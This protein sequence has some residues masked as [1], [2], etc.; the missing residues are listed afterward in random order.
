MANDG[1]SRWTGDISGSVLDLIGRTPLVE[2]TRVERP[3]RARLFAKLELTNPTG[4]LKDRVMR[5]IVER[6]EAAGHLRAG[7]VLVEATS[8]N[9]DISLGMVAAVKGYGCTVYMQRCRSVERRTMMRMWGVDLRLEEG[10]PHAHIHAAEAH[11]ATDTERYYYTYQNGNPWNAEAHYLG[12]GPEILE[13]VG[14]FPVD[15]MVAGFGTG[16]TV[17]GIGRRLREE[18]P[19]TLIVSVE[20]DTSDTRIEGMMLLDGSYVPPIWDASVPDRVLR[21]SD[22]DAMEHSRMLARTEGL[23]VG[24]SSGAV[25]AAGLRVARELG[26]GNVVMVFADRGER[27]LSTALCAEAQGAV[28]PAGQAA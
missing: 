21:V 24:P 12:T 25:I 15:A 10:D 13:Q 1:A 16:G 6:A 9:A 27:Y 7:M 23:F 22:E 20:P 8:G 19:S 14:Q 26:N 3:G 18:S 2:L 5:H 4:S 17:V 11:A 28:D